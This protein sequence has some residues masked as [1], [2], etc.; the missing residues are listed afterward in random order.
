[1][2]DDVDEEQEAEILPP[3][4]VEPEIGGHNVPQALCR[5]PAGLGRG[6]ERSEEQGLVRVKE[7]SL[8]QML[9]RAT[10]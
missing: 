4:P 2:F 5:V 8:E 3:L 10:G 7:Q 6:P 9:F 1:M